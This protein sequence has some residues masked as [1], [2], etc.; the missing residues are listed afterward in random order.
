[1]AGYIETVYN[2][3]KRPQTDYPLK[4]CSH[5]I[6][7]F[8]L[9]AGA[10][11]LD[12]GCGRGDFLN[13]FSLK[14]FRSYGI[15][16]EPSGAKV[17]RSTEIKYCHV[18]KDTFPFEDQT[19]DV[20]FSKSVIEHLS[21]P[22]LFVSE[23]RRVLKPGGRVIIMTPDWLTQMKIFFDDYTHR[24]PYTVTSLNDLLKTSG[25]KDVHAERFYQLPVL[26]RYPVLKVLSK[27]LQRLVPVTTRSPIKFIRW[28]IELMVLGTGVK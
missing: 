27:I 19:F 23:C 1:M 21:D 6:D 18:E 5:L 14:G 7:S 16:R 2:E 8:Y 12:V 13:A 20:V 15:D 3:K 10:K 9:P 11:V 24:Q 28:S 26:W 22:G 17:D 25:F 4:L